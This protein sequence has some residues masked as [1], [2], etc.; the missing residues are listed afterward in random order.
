MAFRAFRWYIDK[1]KDVRQSSRLFNLP[2][3]PFSAASNYTISR[4]LVDVISPQATGKVKAHQVRG[5]ALF[6]RFVVPIQDILKA[7]AWKTLSTF[8]SCYLTDM[9]ADEAAFGRAVLSFPAADRS[10]LCLKPKPVLDCY[11]N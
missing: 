6:A 3:A 9:L 1:T 10:S 11:I 5:H 8:V 7:A 2:R 4:W